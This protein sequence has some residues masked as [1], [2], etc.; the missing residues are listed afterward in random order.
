MAKCAICSKGA[1]FGNS[2]SHSH[3]RSNKIWSANVKSVKVNVNGASKKM[4][5]LLKI[6]F[7]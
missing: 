1:H 2:V 4:Y 3:R 5:V 7:C 6:R